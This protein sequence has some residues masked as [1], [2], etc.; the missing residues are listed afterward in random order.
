[1]PPAVPAALDPAF[2]VVS[3]LSWDNTSD[4]GRPTF[5]DDQVLLTVTSPRSAPIAAAGDADAREAALLAYDADV[6]AHFPRHPSPPDLLSKR[7]ELT[8]ERLQLVR[9]HVRV[10][11]GTMSIAAVDTLTGDAFDFASAARF[12]S[13]DAWGA[14]WDEQAHRVVLDMARLPPELAK[15]LVA[16]F[17]PDRV[18]VRLEP[19]PQAEAGTG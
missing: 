6:R 11:V 7:L 2:A 14:G 12:R 18:A 19:N 15:A 1:M 10:E 17:G 9:E 8:P 5:T 3:R 4:F 16:E 13:A